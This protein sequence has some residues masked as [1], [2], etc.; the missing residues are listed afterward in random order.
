MHELSVCQGLL[1]QLEPLAAEH[2]GLLE[3]VVVRIGPLSGVEPQLLQ[4]AYPIAR[5]DTVASQAELVI[6]KTALRVSCKQCD[7]ESEVS[8]NNLCCRHCG[9]QQTQLISGDE[10]LLVSIHFQ[11]EVDDV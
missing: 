1:R 4:Q 5:Q 6:E 7:E 10:L 8:M 2:Q 11:K 9:S 3:R